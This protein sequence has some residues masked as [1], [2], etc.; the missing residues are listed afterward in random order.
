MSQEAPLA[1]EEMTSDVSALSNS[2][3]LL[4]HGIFF[5]IQLLMLFLVVMVLIGIVLLLGKVSPADLAQTSRYS[6]YFF[7][8]VLGLIISLG[9]AAMLWYLT[10]SIAEE[11]GIECVQDLS[12]SWWPSWLARTPPNG[13][14]LTFYSIVYAI[15]G[16]M[17]TAVLYGM[18]Y[19]GTEKLPTADQP[20]SFPAKVRDYVASSLVSPFRGW[21]GAAVECNCGAGASREN[22]RCQ[23][24][25][26]GIFYGSFDNRLFPEGSPSPMNV[27]YLMFAPLVGPVFFWLI[28]A[29]VPLI[30]FIYFQIAK[31]NNCQ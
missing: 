20:T 28:T 5:F 27:K 19:W 17:L 31:L 11:R 7:Y 30:S 1:E 2:K 18:V 23:N 12:P 29:S 6:P 26:P 14:G 15:V 16:V 21:S 10:N 9:Y 3:S 8:A 22:C 25:I 13:L 4:T 24:K